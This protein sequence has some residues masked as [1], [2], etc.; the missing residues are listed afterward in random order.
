MKKREM[1]GIPNIIAGI[2]FG[3]VDNSIRAPLH[4]RLGIETYV[5]MQVVLC[6]PYDG[7]LGQGVKSQPVNSHWY[8]YPVTLP[9]VLADEPV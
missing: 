3:N 2:K 4:R 1:K 9:K 7:R 5:H 8:R 6:S